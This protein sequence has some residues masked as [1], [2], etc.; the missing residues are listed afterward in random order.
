MV[1]HLVHK[2]DD[3]Q[4]DAVGVLANEVGREGQQYI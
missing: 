2:A 3:G 4:L 1:A